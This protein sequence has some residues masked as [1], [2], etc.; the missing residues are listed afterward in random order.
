[1]VTFTDRDDRRS[2]HLCNRAIQNA[3]AV[4]ER[5]AT[6]ENPQ[7][8]MSR[9]ADWYQ[10]RGNLASIKDTLVNQQGNR[11]FWTTD[12]DESR[13]AYQMLM[14]QMKGGDR[15]ARMMDLR[16]LP[17]VVQSD[18]NRYRRGRTMFQDPSKSQGFL[19]DVGSLFSGNNR[20]AVYADEYNPFPKAGFGKDWYR[21]Q[22]PIASGLGSFM[23]AAE[24]FIPGATWAKQFLPKSKRLPLER[25]L[26]WVPEGV[27]EYD[28]IPEIPFVE[29]V[30]GETPLEAVDRTDDWWYTP[31]FFDE[32]IT[33]TDLPPETFEEPTNEIFNEEVFNKVYELIHPTG[34]T[35]AEIPEHFD[36]F[37]SPWDMFLKLKESM[38]EGE[39]TDQELLDRLIEEG[40][41]KDTTGGEDLISDINLTEDDFEGVA[42]D[43]D[44]NLE[45]QAESLNEIERLKN[46]QRDNNWLFDI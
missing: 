36:Q 29:D 20:A 31:P 28:K 4:R 41:L 37:E 38:E 5:R 44:K 23:E 42:F 16:G 40:Y 22:F 14:N 17:S 43:V 8:A 10:D 33:V 9:D 45:D 35:A 11:D 19:G 34:Q 21:D 25:D 12:Q 1:M 32:D 3:N 30:V 18:P 27:G 13:N 39:W 7:W 6:V 15:G 26:S 46:I 24:N 2:A